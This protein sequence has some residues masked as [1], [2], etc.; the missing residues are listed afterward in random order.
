MGFDLD[1][2]IVIFNSILERRPEISRDALKTDLERYYL[3]YAERLMEIKHHNDSSRGLVI[4]ISALQGAGKTTHGEIMCTLLA[5]LGHTSTVLSIDDHYVTHEQLNEI[6]RK[7]PRFI[8][9]GVTHDIPMA[10]KNLTALRDMK[11]GDEVL[12]PIY[13]KGAMQG[14]GDRVG[15]KK[16]TQKPDIIFYDGWMVG[17]RR[18]KDESVFDPKLPGLGK[19]GDIEFAKDVNRKLDEYLPLWDL[20]DFIQMLYIP[21]YHVSLKWREQAE[22]RLRSQGKGGMTSE[23]IR[24]FVYYFWRSVHPAIQIKNLAHSKEYT[25]QVTIINENHDVEEILTPE[26]TAVKYP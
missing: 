5:H 17:V 25:Q 7:D 14:D 26:Q 24:E 1:K 4:G 3:P 13:D 9:R 2:D 12:I 21:N 10:V 15:W 19:P 11:D 23:Q 20:L 18:V 6:R 22:V 16:I 8:R